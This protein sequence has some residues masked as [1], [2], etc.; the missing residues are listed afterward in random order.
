MH[1]SKVKTINCLTCTYWN[2]KIK[3]SK[4]N[5]GEPLVISE[6]SYA[7]CSNTRS[8]FFEEHRFY[9]SKCINHSPRYEGDKN[10]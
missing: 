6:N 2:S 7:V 1:R 4:T 10:K 3:S 9:K 8:R 5:G